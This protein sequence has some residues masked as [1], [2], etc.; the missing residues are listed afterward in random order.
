MTGTFYAHNFGLFWGDRGSNFC[1]AQKV[2]W[3]TEKSFHSLFSG[4]TFA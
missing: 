3:R 4:S 1:I 2:H